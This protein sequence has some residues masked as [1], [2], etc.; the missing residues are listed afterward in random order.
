SHFLFFTEALTADDIAKLV[1]ALAV[2]DKK[3]ESKKESTFEKV[4]VKPISAESRRG[5]SQ[6]LGVDVK[7]LEPKPKAIDPN[8]LSDSTAEKL[9][10]MGDKN[11]AAKPAENTVLVLWGNP[12]RAN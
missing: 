7:W 10:K 9:A 4:V 5:L 1:Q 3:A 6:L 8:K 2:E 11:A 12:V